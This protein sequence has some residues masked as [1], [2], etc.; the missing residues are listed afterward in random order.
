MQA[1]KQSELSSEEEEEEE[2]EDSDEENLEQDQSRVEEKEEAV[3][4]KEVSEQEEEKTKEVEE[5]LKKP[6]VRRGRELKSYDKE[7]QEK[8]EYNDHKMKT[9]MI[10]PANRKLY[11]KLRDKENKQ[12]ERSNFLKEKRERIE[13]HKIGQ[14]TDEE[15]KNPPKKK[16]KL[17]ITDKKKKAYAQNIKSAVKFSR[18]VHNKNRNKR[19]LKK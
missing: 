9:F 19:P 6:E 18:S 2:E 5:E 14:I 7:K 15:L 12:T 13:K 16:R 1:S 3:S 8:E 17:T 4:E 11:R 10:H